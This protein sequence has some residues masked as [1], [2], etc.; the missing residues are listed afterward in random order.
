MEVYSKLFNLIPDDKDKEWLARH[1]I[2]ED[3]KLELRLGP[4]GEFLGYNNITH[5]TKRVFG[6]SIEA[7]TGDK[8]W[9]TNGEDKKIN[10]TTVESG[11]A[12]SFLAT[13][14]ISK[15]FVVKTEDP[16]QPCSSVVAEL[17]HPDT[18]T[19]LN[20]ASASSDRTVTNNCHK[21]MATAPV[22][23]WPPIRSFRKNL[24]S[25]SLSKPTSDSLNKQSKEESGR[26]H[27]SSTNNSFV[28]V[29]ME[30]VPIGRKINL[31]AYDSY[32]KLFC[33][34]DELF[35]GLLAAQRDSSVADNHKEMEEANTGSL[36]TS[37]ENTLVY[38]DNEGDRMLVG[39]VP[40]H[41]FVSAVKRLRVL[42]S[43]GLSTLQI[44]SREE[45][46]TPLN[47]LL[48]T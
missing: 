40:W 48:E 28:K 46:K 21:R 39:D 27:E 22:V 23:G 24:A 29:N 41:M 20:P 6:D 4:P 3:N 47:S 34:I 37:G 8:Y 30:G 11:F 45:E 1:E 31:S 35:R 42:N 36:A 43:S 25:D 13:P 10:T 17:Q 44:G 18:K 2:S 9:F 38:E 16:L 14:L 15:R 32:E 5:G 19:S 26:E 12:N 7:K 33:A